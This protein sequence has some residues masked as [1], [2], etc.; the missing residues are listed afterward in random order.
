MVADRY[1][2]QQWEK[3]FN[4]LQNT[5][6]MILQSV[7]SLFIIIILLFGEK[8]CEEIMT[9]VSIELIMEIK[10]SK[11]LQ[12]S[13]TNIKLRTGAIRW[14]TLYFFRQGRPPTQHPTHLTKF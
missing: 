3:M 10:S 7:A 5:I 1:V 13:L 11:G 9:C 2:D 12:R 8:M 4:I 6:F 14:R